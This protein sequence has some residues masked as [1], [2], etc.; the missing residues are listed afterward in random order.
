MA[1]VCWSRP[2]MVPCYGHW[3]CHR[4]RPRF[5]AFAE[6]CESRLSTGSA[7]C[8]ANKIDSP[9]VLGMQGALMVIACTPI[10][11]PWVNRLMPFN[12]V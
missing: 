5:T 2:L 1:V 11:D 3:S 8:L 12:R 10:G 4:T 7:S 6:V 9:P